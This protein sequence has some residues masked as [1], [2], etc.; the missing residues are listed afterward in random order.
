MLMEFFAQ[1]D[2]GRQ[3]RHSERRFAGGAES[4]KVKEPICWFAG[5]AWVMRL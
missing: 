2:G 3:S 4:E 5:S 1:T